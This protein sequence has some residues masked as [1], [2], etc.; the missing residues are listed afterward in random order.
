MNIMLQNITFFPIKGGIET[1]LY[2]VAKTLLKLG[3]NPIIFV[4]Q[5]P[6]S[7]PTCENF[8]GIQIVRVPVKIWQ[9]PFS[10][11]NPLKYIWQLKMQL[12][13]IIFNYNIKEIWSRHPYFGY[14]SIQLGFPLRLIYIPATAFPKY[15]WLVSP[16]K[17]GFKKPIYAMRLQLDKHLE[18]TVLKR[19]NKVYVLSKSKKEEICEYYRISKEKILSNPPGVD[20]ERFTPRPKNPK[21]LK[22]LGLGETD[23]VVL[24]VGR[25]SPEKNVDML[26]EAF[27]KVN[28]KH[29]KLLIVG[30][31][32][33]MRKLRKKAYELGINLNTIFTGERQ[34]VE[35]FYNIAYVLVNPSFTEGFGHVFLE[36]MASGVPPIAFK[37]KPP[38]VLT[39]TEE[40]FTHEKE[41]IIVDNFSVDGLAAAI[42]YL[43]RHPEKQKQMSIS[44]YRKAR[45]KFSWEFHVCSLLE[46]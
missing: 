7:L 27:A 17:T 25:L 31:G 29:K 20:T 12:S 9:G 45:E 30:D 36:A 5:K 42:E 33:E 13:S 1:Y 19:A 39:A 2:Y 34:D 4:Q 10:V 22:E 35:F 16:N 11:I 14:A 37:S 44:C 15:L 38:N 3:H 26:L 23:K 41:G 24:F 46:S 32:P 28:E 8:E 43:L 40:I 21:L 18:Y 6:E